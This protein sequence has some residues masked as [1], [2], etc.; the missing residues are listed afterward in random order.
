MSFKKST[1][2]KYTATDLTYPQKFAA[3]SYQHDR[4]SDE[5]Y[6]IITTNKDYLATL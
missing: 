4:L 2:T 5:A 3:Y 1:L 6:Q